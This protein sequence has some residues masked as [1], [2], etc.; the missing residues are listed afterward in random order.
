MELVKILKSNDGSQK[1]IFK[2]EQDDYNVEAVSFYEKSPSH[3]RI[4]ISS[5]LGCAMG[6]KFCLTGQIGFKRNIKCDEMIEMVNKILEINKGTDF[7]I[8]N[9]LFMGMG[10]PLNNYDEVISFCEK[11]GKLFSPKHIIISTSGIP[12]R[13]VDLAN[14][15][16][17]IELMVS[18]H[19]S[20]DATRNQI[21]PINIAHP[22]ENLIKACTIFNKITNKKV[23][24]SYM[25]IKD[26]NDSLED[27][28]KLAKIL[29]HDI[30]EIQILL[31]NE[32]NLLNFK[33]P[34]GKKAEIV[35]EFLLKKGFGVDINISKGR[36]ILGACGQLSGK[37]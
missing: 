2:F 21:M 20:N 3:S 22:L 1:Y 28:N 35:Q 23:I 7:T 31:Y 29:N 11:A 10:E 24:M 30:F 37:E 36:D 13:I 5:Q 32:T 9:I 26:Y 17:D 16:L 12:Q 8:E 6:C 18:L 34:V 33:R 19:A 4:C 25:L 14:S 27:I 15:K